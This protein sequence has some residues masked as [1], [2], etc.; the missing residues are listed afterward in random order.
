[1]VCSRSCP[2]PFS[3]FFL[4]PYGSNTRPHLLTSP[5]PPFPPSSRPSPS[6]PLQRRIGE[7]DDGGRADS[8]LAHGGVQCGEEGG[9]EGGTEGGKGKREGVVGKGMEESIDGLFPFQLLLPYTFLTTPTHP[10]APT[11]PSTPTCPHLHPPTDLHPPYRRKRRSARR[12]TRS[13][14]V[15]WRL[16]PTGAVVVEVRVWGE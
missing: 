15:F 1:M 11:H 14:H 3:P 13:R 7:P 5:L 2:P 10:R 9:R 6:A 16:R 8:L 4:P 12:R